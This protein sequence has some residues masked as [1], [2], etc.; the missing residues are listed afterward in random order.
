MAG[1]SQSERQTR[2]ARGR[3]PERWKATRA[4][5]RRVFRELRFTARAAAR[6]PSGAYS[7]VAPTGVLR[8]LSSCVRPPGRLRR[9]RP[10]ALFKK[11]S[12]RQVPL[13]RA[14]TILPMNHNHRRAPR[15]VVGCTIMSP[16][17]T[18]MLSSSD[19]P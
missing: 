19:L 18:V 16:V 1:A 15:L 6:I 2:V 11:P 14:G 3:R 5:Q 17:R 9:R 4:E 7:R 13:S 12:L 10:S 8:A